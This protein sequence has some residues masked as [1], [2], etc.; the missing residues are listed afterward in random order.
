VRAEVVVDL[1]YGSTGKGA[2]A[3][4]LVR[5]RSFDS[6]VRVQS[7]QAGHTVYY[8]GL[9][10]KMRTIPCA[11]VDPDMRLYLGPG[12]FIDKQLLLDEVAVIKAATGDDVRN[13]LFLDYRA[14]YVLP[15]DYEVERSS[16]IEGK[17]GSTAHGAGAS[18]VRK[19]ARSSPSTRV[20]DDGWALEHGFFVVDAVAAIQG[21]SVLVEGCQGTMLSVHTS[22]YY[23]F[24]TSRECTVSGIIAEA[25]IAPRDVSLVHGVF[26]TYPIRVG[27]NSGP[28]GGDEIGWGELVKRAGRRMAPELTTVTGRERRIFEFSDD[29]FEKALMLNKPDVLYMTFADYLGPGIYGRR[30]LSSLE[31]EAKE[32]L[33]GF[34]ERVEKKHGVKVSWVGTGEQAEDFIVLA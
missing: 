19:L 24:V 14:N 3:A 17:I 26:R 13:R 9:P 31:P 16:G 28:T 6:S 1:Q 25:G 27:G 18:L 11:W 21:D 30:S 34:V 29:D 20:A 4:Y 10:Y 15:C 33:L 23:P 22:P 32:A 5:R 8:G 12:C 2:V 7:I